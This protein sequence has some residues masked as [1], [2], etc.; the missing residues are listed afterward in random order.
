M[1]HPEPDALILQLTDLV[2]TRKCAVRIDAGEGGR[3]LGYLLDKYVK[4][5]P[6]QDLVRDARVTPNSAGSLFAIQDL[7]YV[8]SDKGQLLDMYSGVEFKQGD[9][10]IE[11]EEAP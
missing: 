4:D 11:P 1:Q 7:L 9:R 3:T 8:S 6:I 2:S 5:V 10:M